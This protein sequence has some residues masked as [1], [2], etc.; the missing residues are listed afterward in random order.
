M[1][2]SDRKVW[3]M[4]PGLE[5]Y[6]FFTLDRWIN[7]P[8]FVQICENLLDETGINLIDDILNQI[9][10][11]NSNNN[12]ESQPKMA[13]LFAMVTALQTSI[14][15]FLMHN[16]L[17]IKGC[18]GYSI[19]EFSC[20]FVDGCY[21]AITA[22]LLSHTIGK[23]IDESG[24]RRGLMA[25]VEQ[26]EID[27]VS[28]FPNSG[29]HIVAHNSDD[30]ISIAGSETCVQGIIDTLKSDRIKCQII[31]SFN[32]PLHCGEMDFLRDTAME[33]LYRV[34]DSP[35]KRSSNWI[36]TTMSSNQDGLRLSCPRYFLRNLCSPV[37]FRE[38]CQ[39]I[40][41]DS[42]VIEMSTHPL[43]ERWLRANTMGEI[44]Y[45]PIPELQ[46]CENSLLPGT[47]LCEITSTSLSH[48][49]SNVKL[50]DYAGEKK[51][52]MANKTSSGVYEI[53]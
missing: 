45:I 14:A 17:T 24:F 28:R 15:K 43:L 29:V 8:P 1:T 46:N 4:F 22:I 36:S 5:S 52:I 11:I 20:G 39:E 38:A 16:G 2:T 33:N 50:I 31:P 10:A 3:L 53:R 23:K 48:C 41:S 25:V 35:K 49:F 37:L 18:I 19:G 12:N 34:I 30:C 26:N 32:I 44:T 6:S 9:T 47:S 27:F 51:K 7:F 40:P 21:D 13:T 42:V